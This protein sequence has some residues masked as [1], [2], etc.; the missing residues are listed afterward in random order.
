MY[1]RKKKNYPVKQ[2]QNGSNENELIQFLLRQSKVTKEQ[3]KA[4]ENLFCLRV[5]IT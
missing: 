2:K 4:T 5:A 1:E 3:L